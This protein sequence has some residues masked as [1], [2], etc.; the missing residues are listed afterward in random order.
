MPPKASAAAGVVERDGERL[1]GQPHRDRGDVDACDVD[2]TEGRA[3]ALAGRGEQRVGGDMHLVV[4]DLADR[5][6]CPCRLVVQA[7]DADAVGAGVDGEHEHVARAALGARPAD[8]HEHVGLARERHPGL[9]AGHAP[10]IVDLDRAG[11]D[12]RGV[13]TGVRLGEREAA[14]QLAAHEA[15]GVAVAQ[16]G[17][18]EAGDRVGDGVVHREREGVG[19]VAAPELL[20][21]VHRLGQ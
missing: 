11:R 15:R 18:A 19:R 16:L 6:E 13:R 5:Q 17:L 7:L 21:D 10:A 14:Q 8:Q 20:E 1:G 4:G 12:R 9:A 3:H 2:G